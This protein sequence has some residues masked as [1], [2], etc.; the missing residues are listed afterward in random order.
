MS[1]AT[2]NLVVTTELEAV[3]TMLR[4]IGEAPISDLDEPQLIS[5]VNAKSTLRFVS[6][7]VQS[8]GWNFNTQWDMTLTRDGNNKVPVGSDVLR[9]DTYGEHAYIPVTKRGGFLFNLEDNTFVWD[10]NPKCTLIYFLSFTDLPESARVYITIRAARM[11]QRTE[12]GEDAA[13]FGYGERDEFDAL[14]LLKE[15]E[16]DVGDHNILTDNYDTYRT[17]DRNLGAGSVIQTYIR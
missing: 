10:K 14:A 6:R 15:A 7:L 16:G 8:Q 17:L 2:S 1:D 4:G 11:F 13:G 9:V 5:A 12:I 3:N